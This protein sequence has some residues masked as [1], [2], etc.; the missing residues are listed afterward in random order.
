M[1]RLNDE[2]KK[3]VEDIDKNIKNKE[4]LLFIKQRL[5]TFVDVVIEEME[6]VL[7]F[8][9]EKMNDL[10]QKQKELD[11]K[12][13]KMQQILDN[14]EK[15]IYTDEG[16]DFEIVCPYCNYE[17]VIDMDE[18][19][20]EVQCPECQNMIELDWSGNPDDEEN[21]KCNGSCSGCSGCDDVEETEEPQKPSS[22]SEEDDM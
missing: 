15:D 17:F 13:Y 7:H 9:E 6:S 16:F 18:E 4:D 2:Y 3:F 21:F 20:T 11:S 1:G 10:E 19:K 8:K 5:T 22:K 14:I 12:I